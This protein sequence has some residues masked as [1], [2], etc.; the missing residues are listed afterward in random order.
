MAAKG[1]R[2]WLE[3]RKHQGVL[4]SSLYAVTVLAGGAVAFL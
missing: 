1:I 4:F 2:G 3:R